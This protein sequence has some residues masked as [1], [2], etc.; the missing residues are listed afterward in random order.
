MYIYTTLRIIYILHYIC[1]YVIRV[2]VSHLAD[3][4]ATVAFIWEMDPCWWGPISSYQTPLFFSS[5]TFPLSH[6]QSPCTILFIFFNFFFRSVV[7]EVCQEQ[8]HHLSG[9]HYHCSDRQKEIS[10]LL[11]EYALLNKGTITSLGF[12]KCED[13]HIY[14]WL[15]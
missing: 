8:L 14:L 6:R 13:Y 2:C 9:F 5:F 12:S 11:V 3:N 1:V 15:N 7:S 4:Y 10:N